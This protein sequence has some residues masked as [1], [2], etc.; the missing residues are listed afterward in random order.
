MPSFFASVMAAR[1]QAAADSESA[2]A[3]AE[4]LRRQNPPSNPPANPNPRPYYSPVKTTTTVRSLASPS[5]GYVRRNEGGGGGMSSELEDPPPASTIAVASV[6]QDYDLIR[7]EL[8]HQEDDDSSFISDAFKSRA[9]PA[10]PKGGSMPSPGT[11][12]LSPYKSVEASRVNASRKNAG[13]LASAFASRA[14]SAAV[15]NGRGVNELGTSMGDMEPLLPEGDE[16]DEDEWDCADLDPSLISNLAAMIDKMNTPSAVV[17]KPKTS[18]GDNS[19]ISVIEL[20]PEKEDVNRETKRLDVDITDDK[21]VVDDDDDGLSDILMENQTSA[22]MLSNLSQLIDQMNQRGQPQSEDIKSVENINLEKPSEDL[23]FPSPTTTSRS[24]FED[25]APASKDAGDMSEA[26]NKHVFNTSVQSGGL[27]KEYAAD[28]LVSLDK[29]VLNTSV[30]LKASNESIV[31]NTSLELKSSNECVIG[32]MSL[33]SKA[34]NEEIVGNTPVEQ[35]ASNECSAGSTLVESKSSKDG[36]VYGTSIDSKAS[37]DGIVDNTSAESKALNECI[38]CIEDHDQNVAEFDEELAGQ[39]A[40]LHSMVRKAHGELE[41]RSDGDGDESNNPEVSLSEDLNENRRHEMEHDGDSYDDGS[42]SAEQI[43]ELENTYEP[44]NEPDDSVSANSAEN[45]N[46]DQPD[47]GS[48]NAD[49]DDGPD[50][51]EGASELEIN[52]LNAFLLKLMMISEVGKPSKEDLDVLFNDAKSVGLSEE[53]VLQIFE[54]S[55]VPEQ[56]GKE[57]EQNIKENEQIGRENEQHGKEN[58]KIAKAKKSKAPKKEKDT[59]H[60]G[61]RQRVFLANSGKFDIKQFWVSPWDMRYTTRKGKKL[62]ARK[63][64]GSNGDGT[65]D[66]IPKIKSVDVVKI[67][68]KRDDRPSSKGKKLRIPTKQHWKLSKKD[69]SRSH[70][71]IHG[72]PSH[73]NNPLMTE[74]HEFDSLKWEDR[75]VEQTFLAP[76]YAKSHWF[77]KLLDQNEL[78]LFHVF[79]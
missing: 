77:G 45:E 57:S 37:N 16:G 32:S 22:A 44:R 69:P 48:V 40:Q 76:I 1:K 14:D 79:V 12:Y 7:Q 11:S 3:V 72:I 25:N 75:K 47:V 34:S 52:K 63:T 24:L 18:M 71:G 74:S 26:L 53:T 42:N 8:Q 9:E 65:M 38:V 49:F 23:A 70:D 20:S 64:A 66:S 27:V 21:D 68:L 60:S 31:S 54:E 67:W 73:Y 58:E 35:N 17:D 13:F 4:K 2:N 78:T 28:R 19:D 36:V 50:L 59:F 62:K 55:S 41:F 15:D 29:S 33:E 10:T 30:Q 39:I 43:L 5:D 56:I 6:N 51:P 46:G 61:V